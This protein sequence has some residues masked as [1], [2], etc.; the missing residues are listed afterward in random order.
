MLRNLILCVGLAVCAAT[1]A[2][3][4]IAIE[5]NKGKLVRLARPATAVMVA[6]PEIADIEVKSPQIV[7]VYGKKIGETSLSVLDK[8]DQEVLNATVSVTHNLSRLR[9]A[10]KSLTP[11]AKVN[12]STLDGAL[13]ISGNVDSPLM[14]ERVQKIAT[15][16]S[17]GEHGALVNMMKISGSDQVTLKVRVA[18][19][20][21]SELKEFGINLETLLSPGNFSFGLL[22]GRSFLG[23]GGALIRSATGANGLNAHFNAGDTDINGLVDALAKQGLMTVLAEP[24]LTAISGKPARFLAGGEFPV[25]VVGE[26][27]AVSISFREYGISLSFTP[28][29][30]SKE[31][32]SLTV[33]PE[34]STLSSQGSVTANGFNIPSLATRRAE[35]TVELGSGQSFAIAGLLQNDSNNDISKFPALGDV[36]VLGALF[37]STSFKQNQTE[38]VILITPYIVQGVNPDRQM[39]T[40]IEGY[41]PAS[42]IERVFGGQETHEE[43]IAARPANGPA[44]FLLR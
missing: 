41:K 21:R 15:S 19:V 10:V 30:L 26:N 8:D 33:A 39:A 3:A 35:T 38:L 29:V 2:F 18:E 12:F 17:G 23:A 16:F 7:Y 13:V 27:G 9:Q 11:E 34:V 31:K 20:A 44:G 6:D 42:D 43:E 25:P 1:P 5:V 37:R 28:T 4:S 14:A 40:P 24:N 36:P 22:S 32:I